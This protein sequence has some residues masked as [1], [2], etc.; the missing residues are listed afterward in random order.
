M[1]TPQVEIEARSPTSLRSRG[2]KPIDFHKKRLFIQV[3]TFHLEKL[4]IPT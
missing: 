3:D 4:T 1:P 2:S